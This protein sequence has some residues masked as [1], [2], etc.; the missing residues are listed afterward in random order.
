MDMKRFFSVLLLAGASV[1]C[2]YAQLSGAGYYR[3]KNAKTGR[4]MSLRDDKSRG[5]HAASTTADCGAMATSRLDNIKYDPGSVFYLEHISGESYNVVG[6]GT[7][8]H[9]IINY[10]IYLTP[11]GKY[12]KAWQE[13][14]GQRVC[15]SDPADSYEE[16]YVTTSSNNTNWEIIPLDGSNE[17]MGIKPTMSVGGKHYAA[18]FAG[19]PFTL[20]SGMK[21]YYICKIDEYR[22]LVVY[23]ELTGI[24][25]AKTPVLIECSSTEV[26]DNKVTPVVSSL[27]VPSDN[28]AKGVYFCIGNPWSG[29]FNSTVFQPEGMR[30]LSLGSDGKLAL[31]TSEDYLTTV[32]IEKEDESGQN[33]SVM[34]ISANS[35][36]LPVSNSAPSELK[37][38]TEKEYATGVENV[39][40]SEATAYNVY[41]LEGVQ[42]RKNAKTLDGLTRGVYV[43]NGKKIVVGNK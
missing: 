11:V 31:T 34:A 24:V 22:G 4:Y 14:K 2:A 29:H 17:Y 12:Y 19:Y 1:F 32:D 9:D 3:V 40:A 10:Y 18:V 20:D 25:P 16:G 15:L 26:V 35:W 23:K 6:Q 8:L 7:S 13:E 27:S 21:A 30:V 43:V 33:L 28:K 39:T 41:T 38:V 36:Y 42:V 5:V 37:L